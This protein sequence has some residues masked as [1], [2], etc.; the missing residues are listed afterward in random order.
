MEERRWPFEGTIAGPYSNDP[1]TLSSIS[2]WSV[3]RV[4][5]N[6]KASGSPE[7]RFHPNDLGEFQSTAAEDLWSE[8]PTPKP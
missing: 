8:N 7:A 3:I 4:S 1:P 6:A 5:L 2:N